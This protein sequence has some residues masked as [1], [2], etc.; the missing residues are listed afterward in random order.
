MKTVEDNS[1]CRAYLRE[2]ERNWNEQHEDVITD[3]LWLNQ[4][5]INFEKE[6]R[7]AGVTAFVAKPILCP[8]FVLS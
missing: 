6:A 8:N 7:E 2:Y 4:I 5:L 3:K 1:R